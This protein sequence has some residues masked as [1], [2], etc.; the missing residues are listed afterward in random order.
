MTI[1]PPQIPTQ[2]VSPG[3]VYVCPLCKVQTTADRADTGWT[4]CPMLD[5]PICLGC[6]VDHQSVAVADEF[7]R[8]P[9]RDL[10]D[11]VAR[12]TGKDVPTLRRIC[13]EH[14]AKVLASIPDLPDDDEDVRAV[15]RALQEL[16]AP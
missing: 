8:H 5:L 9:Y 16:E 7:S 6:C 12:L 10:F 2:D 3:R 4:L 15:A 11:V 14:Q 13:V 1:I